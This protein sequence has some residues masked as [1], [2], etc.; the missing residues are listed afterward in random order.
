MAWRAARH[1]FQA[2]AMSRNSTRYRAIVVEPSST[3]DII[4]ILF[5]LIV[6]VPVEGTYRADDLCVNMLYEFFC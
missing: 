4:E 3:R 5:K 6:K 1:V 2:R